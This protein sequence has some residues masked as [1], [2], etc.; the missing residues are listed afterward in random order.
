MK[1]GGLVSIRGDAVTP[2]A[3]P[4]QAAAVVALKDGALISYGPDVIELVRSSV[5]YVDK[6]LKGSKPADLPIER[7]TR[8]ELQVNMKTAKAIDLPI[9]EFFL[10]RADALIE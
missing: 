2:S 3:S 7:P 10:L 5:G 9:P 1:P 6:V 8:F 4:A